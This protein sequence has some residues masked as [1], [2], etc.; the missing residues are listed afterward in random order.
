MSLSRAI[1]WTENCS[2]LRNLV[3]IKY[4]TD[5]II[6]FC[7]PRQCITLFSGNLSIDNFLELP[8]ILEF[9]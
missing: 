6:P 3:V 8:Q 5:N 1:N 4:L 9:I 7:D 2:M